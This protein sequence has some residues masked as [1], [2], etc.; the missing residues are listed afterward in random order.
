MAYLPILDEQQQ[1]L[2]AQHPP[3][4]Q[5]L[6]L[7]DRGPIT[8]DGGLEEGL[9]PPSIRV[10]HDLH[11]REEFLIRFQGRGHRGDEHVHSHA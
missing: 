4:L 2:V 8:I 10:N 3:F 7:Q 11:I 1:Y 9:W 6:I 5:E